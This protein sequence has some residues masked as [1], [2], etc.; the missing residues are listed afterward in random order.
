MKHLG[1]PTLGLP[2]VVPRSA[3]ARRLIRKVW[4][5]GQQ[6]PLYTG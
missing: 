1:L 3:L 6:Q 2:L 4:R 5:V